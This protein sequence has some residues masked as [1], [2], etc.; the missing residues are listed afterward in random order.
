M[1]QEY[2]L[3]PFTPTHC[4]YC[5]IGFAACQEKSFI[6]FIKNFY[7]LRYDYKLPVV[8]QITPLLRLFRVCP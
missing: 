8:S 5:D 6:K 2:R 3:Q 7:D 1:T 4:V